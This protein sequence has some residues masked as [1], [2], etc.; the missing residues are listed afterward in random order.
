MNKETA[1]A[2]LA[3]LSPGE[4]WDRVDPLA[5]DLDLD[6]GRAGL[7]DLPYAKLLG[8][9]FERLCYELLVAEGH[10]PRFFGRSG[11]RDYGVDIVVETGDTRTVYQCKNIAAAP[12]WTDVRDAVAKFESDWLGTADLPSPH[13]FVYC[14]PHPLDDKDFAEPWTPFR[15]EFR[16][17]TG[18]EVSFWDKDALDT[19]LRRLPDVV[20]GLFSGSYAEHFCGR[21]YWLL[22]DPWIRLCRGEAR[23]R[24]IK[25]FLERHERGAIHVSL[26]NEERFLDLLS[27]SGALAIRGMPGS[28]KTFWALE[29]GCRMR[30]PLR[31]LYYVTLTE[32]SDIERIWQSARRRRSLPALFVLDDCHQNLEGAGRILERLTP[33]LKGDTVKLLLVLRDLPR[34][35]SGGP[36]DTP[37]WLAQLKQDGA[38]IDMKT[39]DLKRTRAVTEH[40]RPDLIGLS[41]QRLERLHHFSGAGDLMCLDELLSDVTSPL[42]VDAL[43]HDKLYQNIRSRYFKGN[44]RLPTIRRLACLAQFELT[45]F[46]SVIDGGWEPGEKNFAAPLMT[47]LFAPPRYFFLHSSLAE[48]VLRAL[49]ALEIEPS[50]LEKHVAEATEDELISYFRRLMASCTESAASDTE[51]ITSLETLVKNRLNLLEETM[52]ERIKANLL[53]DEDILAGI[54]THVDRCTFTFL[55]ICFSNL[56]SAAHPAKGRYAELIE[57]RFAV[58]VSRERDRSETFE[59]ATGGTEFFM[60]A[61]YAPVILE[62]VQTEHGAERFV[63]NS[64]LVELF[65]ILQYAT[66][67]FREALLGQLDDATAAA[68]VEKTI[69]AG[70]SIGTLDLAMR[71]LGEADEKLEEGKRLLGRL[72]QAIGAER[73]LRLITANGTLYELFMILKNATPAFREKLLGQFDEATAGALVEKTI[74]AGRSIGTLHLAMRELGEADEKLEEDKRLLGRLE[75]AIGAGSIVRLIGASG[76]LFELFHILQYTT[77]TFREALLGQLGDANAG[78]LVDKTIAAGRSIESFHYSLRQLA[79]PSS[80]RERL[81]GLLGI[82]GWW[83]LI[84]GVG[85]LYSV[86]K[87]SQAMSD[88]F[89]LRFIRASSELTSEDWSGITA[90]GLYLNACTFVTDELA[91]Y[92]ALS[93]TAFR[94]ALAHGA[95]PLAAKASWFDLNPSRPPTDLASVEGRILREALQ[96]RIK[97]F[98]VEELIGLDFREAVNAFAFGWREREDLHP[99]L[100]AHLWHIIPD[101]ARWPREDGEFAAFRLVLVIARSEA[102]S[103]QDAL[104]LL[105]ATGSFL[106]REVCKDIDT[107]PLFLLLWNMAALRYERAADRSFHGTLPANPIEI[108]LTVLRERVRPK[109]PN[110]EKLAQLALAGLLRFLL[111]QFGNEL[112]GIL[113]P[114]TTSTRWLYNEALEQTFLPV[115]FALEGIAL[116]QPGEPVLTPQVCLGLR[117]KFKAYEEV[118]P[119]IEH[120]CER[121]KRHGNLR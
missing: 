86:C 48:L 54:E 103:Q 105:S 107:L 57:E 89:R 47:E 114:L 44:R 24:S 52:E 99:D 81:Q 75:Q 26:E 1:A 116:L 111:P 28:G 14:C 5:P 27:G 9:G 82:D 4:V 109:G 30:S 100:A 33:E 110:D 85:S 35:A 31:R 36:D 19:H 83:R 16:A 112:R 43:R 45:P 6:P 22:D 106:D 71:E 40:L 68:L 84:I 117:W 96:P 113:A 20:A 66:P 76:S 29:L 65:R 34:S 50:R 21:D 102:I 37:E 72:E 115:L 55:A 56:S 70:R 49:T 62:T 60:L 77:P 101:S 12:A 15:D 38:I 51:P 97:A 108:L 90:R 2:P 10:S 119:A 53:A 104:R 118:G 64:T 67:T 69:A 95:A 74:A 92:P 3:L 41:T 13:C 42:D 17:R 59:P 94:A 87:L 93:Q 91:A 120:L 39:D 18:V 32:S 46:A 25:R 61:R 73:F 8:P 88:D 63:T 79:Q 23:Y 11:Q 80:Q 7:A 78:M 121:V 98:K 58:S